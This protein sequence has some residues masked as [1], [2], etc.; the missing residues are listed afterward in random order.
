[1][2]EVKPVFFRLSRPLSKL[3]PT[4]LLINL[5]RQHVVIPFYHVV[6]D[7]HLPHVSNLYRVKS[8][9]AFTDDLDYLLRHFKPIDLQT[10]IKSIDE[11]EILKGD[12][13]L[14]TFDDGLREFNDVVAPVLKKK[15]VP[16]VN[17]LN[18]GFLDNRGLFFR[19]K[20]SLLLD[21]SEN[22]SPAQEAELKKC[23]AAHSF[24]RFTIKDNLRAVGYGQQD[25]LNE[26]AVIL[27]VDFDEFLNDYRPYMTTDQVN[28]WLKE[29]FEFGAHSIDHPE[30][31]NIAM[32]EQIH[33]ATSSMDAI[34]SGFALPYRA[35]AFPFTDEG[36]G[37]AF[38]RKMFEEKQ[39]LDVSFGGAG[40]KLDAYKRNFQRIPMEVNNFSGREILKSELL[41]YWCKRALGKHQ[42][43]RD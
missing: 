18:S 28:K 3:L 24:K 31:R 33:Q 9:K 19:Y 32:D 22:M 14:L 25:L 15:G 13:F 11:P 1:M 39:Q 5:T 40:L 41:Y 17:F 7:E 38:F 26:L 21:K 23:L 2:S 29:G 12:H 6:S 4:R 43:E 8:V 36:I 35:F 16:C 20:V 37:W 42:I 10:F 30:F 34:A 27:S